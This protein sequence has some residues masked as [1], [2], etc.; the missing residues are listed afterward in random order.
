MSRTQVKSKTRDEAEQG[1]SLISDGL[2]MLSGCEFS[3]GSAL[4]VDVTARLNTQFLALE[5]ILKP[6][7]EEMKI[8]VLQ[9]YPNSNQ[10]K[11]VVKGT[12]Y[13]ANVIKIVKSYP[14]FQK[15]KEFFGKKWPQYQETREELQ[16]SF[17][18]KE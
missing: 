9:T 11:F 15:I 14:K 10:E 1:L 13:Q 18:V 5:K 3:R 6:L 2:E 7:K 16:V 17:G 12:V 4:A 8:E